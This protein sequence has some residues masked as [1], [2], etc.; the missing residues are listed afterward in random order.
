M[1]II[2]EL[3]AHLTVPRCRVCGTRKDRPA[4]VCMGTHVI[5]FQHIW[6]DQ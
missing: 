2:R 1:N 3:I 6:E 5:G 4:D